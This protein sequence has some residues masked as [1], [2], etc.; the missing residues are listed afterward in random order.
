MIRPAGIGVNSETG[1]LYVADRGNGRIS[2][3]TSD[4]DFVKAWGW[5]V[6]ASGPGDKPQ[7]EK[8]EV[9]VS[10]TGGNF[11]L[12]FSN[13]LEDGGSS[14]QTTGPIA[15]DATAETVKGALE[16]LE[17]PVPGDVAVTGPAGGPWT[18]EFTG[19]YADTDVAPLEIANSTLTGTATVETLQGGANFEICDPV[20]GDTCRAGQRDGASPGQFTG[21][22]AV[23]VDEAGDIYVFDQRSEGL[24]NA[25][26]QKFSPAGEFL[27]MFGGEVNKTTSANLC[28]KADIGAGDECGAGVFGSADG[29]FSSGG[30]GRIAAGPGD[31]I[32]VGDQGR[33]QEFEPNG[34]FKGK[35]VGAV[36]AESVQALAVDGAGNF[37]VIYAGKDNVHKLTAAG[38]PA[39]PSSF[40]VVG[41]VAVALDSAGN[42]YAVED[43]SPIVGTP[44]ADPRVVKFDPAGAKL[45]PTAEEVTKKEYFAQK[46]PFSLDGLATVLCK[47][48]ALYVS[49]SSG[50]IS[51]YGEEP[52]CGAPAPPKAPAI[53][54]QYA[55]SASTTSAVVKAEINPR[56]GPPATTYFV[57]YGLEDCAAISCTEQPLSPGEPLG[58]EGNTAVPTAGVVLSNLTPGAVYHY[59][60]VAIKGESEFV[61]AGDDRTFVTHREGVPALPDG[62]AYE[63]VS[64]PQ[65]NIGEIAPRGGINN[66]LLQASHSGEAVSYGSTTAFGE[67]PGAPSTSQY[68]S[69]RG[70]A[71]WSTQNITPPD[72]GGSIE[73]PVRGLSPDL[74][75]AALVVSE[76]PLCCNAT[77][78]V[79]NLYLR[80]NASGA[81]TL[82]SDAAPKLSGPSYCLLYMGA[83]ADSSRVIFSAQGALTA[84]APEGNG[85]NL[86]EWSAAEGLQL[87]S[88][89]P[90]GAPAPP[91]EF[92]NFGPRWSECKTNRTIVKHAISADGERIFWTFDG[93]FEG[94]VN[95]LFARI[96]GS[97]TIQLDAP[98]GGVGPGGGGEFWGA[99]ADGSKVLFTDKNRLTPGANP[100]DLYRYD[101]DAPEGTRLSN[102]TAAAQAANVKALV[103]ASEDTGAVYFVATGVLAEN[104]GASIDAK[105]QPEKAALGQNNVYLWRE[106]EPLRFI[107]RLASGEVDNS[108]FVSGP[109]FRTPRVTPDGEH[110]AFIS[111]AP[112]TGY[113]NT[114]QADGSATR[115]VYLYDAGADELA[116]ASCNPTRARPLGPAALTNWK[117][118]FEQARFLSDD[119]GRL[120]FESFDAL[121]EADLNGARDVY[122]FERS[123]VGDCTGESPSF[124]AASAGC[125]ALISSGKS[126]GGHSYFLDASG[127]GD[128]VFI[129]TFQRLVGSDEDELYDAYDVRVGGGF[130]PPPPPEE[131]CKS[132]ESCRLPA[133]PAP[134]VELPRTG[135]AGPS[136]PLHCHKGKVKRKGK[137]VKKPKKAKRKHQKRAAGRNRGAG[138]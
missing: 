133:P 90:G 88:V 116:C 106:G 118:P 112:L 12:V 97:E 99:S 74:A 114:S 122:Q 71:G 34:E 52:G 23:A 58:S 16:G 67:A 3:F 128:D 2:E 82:A 101:F 8:Q 51:A 56:G 134:P 40:A 76:P 42:L 137:C 75:I 120:F 85:W 138:R 27:L 126:G 95:P 100:G 117:T 72:Q 53:E 119:G 110:L 25:R 69:R 132:A 28:T 129:S 108:N 77:P 48:E 10:A 49:D 68:L 54:A 135:A 4:G 55:V 9:A 124:S 59:R 79:G 11:S 113:D 30:G 92:T 115:Q 83:S 44:T 80:D 32:F 127:S 62:R 123:G 7:N 64:P 19:K 65:K 103:G 111:A 105:G 17:S 87:V 21:P 14:K 102:L 20:V 47:G 70:E 39:T 26:V 130:P 45:I 109:E 81:F 107:A 24:E 131:P 84:D 41:P 22:S 31:T 93:T 37:Y 66:S 15:F 86:Y 13:P 6:V 98:Q 35:V 61:V 104:D 91:R 29:Q 57:E 1:H 5:G 38:A 96:G 33:I 43:P 78:G 89:L 136:N 94:A 121:V 36:A 63:M 46:S 18:I 125:I 60:F 50:H 73:N